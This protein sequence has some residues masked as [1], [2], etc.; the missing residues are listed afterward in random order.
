[1]NSA[2]KRRSC[3]LLFLSLQLSSGC[4]PQHATPL[5]SCV[6]VLGTPSAGGP[7]RILPSMLPGI[8]I[9]SA[10]WE[11]ETS[12]P[13]MS[14]QTSVIYRAYVTASTTIALSQFAIQFRSSEPKEDSILRTPGRML[15]KRCHVAYDC[16]Q[17]GGDSLRPQQ[18]RLAIAFRSVLGKRPGPWGCPQSVQVVDRA[19]RPAR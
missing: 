3:T 19:E 13:E 1:M 5:S 15:L 6:A 18:P 10:R 12:S 14:T 2:R 11:S 8:T 7:L 16:I 17:G 4:F 9:D